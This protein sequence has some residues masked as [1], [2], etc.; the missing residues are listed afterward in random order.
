MANDRPINS[1]T[2]AGTPGGGSSP[3]SSSQS[4]QTWYRLHLWEL[5]PVRDLLVIAVV[6]GIVY[7]GYQ[8]RLVTVP[9]LLAML[10]AYLFEPLVRWLRT[11]HIA[12]RRVAA[13]GIILGAVIFVIVPVT[14]AAGFAVVQAAKS[15]QD[16]T[17]NVSLVE[18]SVAK[19]E[20]DT[21]RSQVRPGP[22]LSI[23]DFLVDAEKQ[24][25]KLA[26]PPPAAQNA[27]LPP[28]EHTQAAA[29]TEGHVPAE[30]D[31][32]GEMHALA[33]MALSWLQE[34]GTELGKS[35]G[36][37]VVGGGAQAVG[38]AVSTA[39]SVG[40]VIFGGLLTAFFFYFFTTGWG[41][42]LDFWEKLIPEANREKTLGMVRR[43]DKAIAGFVRGRILICLI[44][45]TFVTIAYWLAGVPAPLVVGPLVGLLF[46]VP[47]IHIIGVP[48]AMLL[49][50]LDQGMN[51]GS[52]SGMAA[53][54]SFERDWWWILLAPTMIWLIA[55]LSDDYVLT[56]RI[57]GKNTDMSVPTI[58]FASLAGGAIAGLYGLL[59]AIPVAACVKI[60]MDE[61]VWPRVRAWVQGRAKD[62]LPIGKS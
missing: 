13:M 25:R 44:L 26:S 1:P 27:A 50:W 61:L 18:A 12:S 55:Q 42:V 20:D 4:G 57:Q 8:A 28:G 46:V 43:M 23:R 41:D 7:L 33:R 47:M 40:Q 29:D 52:V 37:R 34:H 17:E 6:I 19:P 31:D 15:V 58:L 2:T 53:H 62:F 24:H 51:G 21:L 16:V 59:I 45:A 56:P 54:F 3:P 5:Q 39:F 60:L 22:W 10:L 9:M 38:A 35:L 48:I 14:L 49:M 32:S 11:R 36:Q 30:Y